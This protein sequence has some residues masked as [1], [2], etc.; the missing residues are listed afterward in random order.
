MDYET[1]ESGRG[2]TTFE[3]HILPQFAS[4]DFLHSRNKLCASILYQVPY[5]FYNI[6]T[7]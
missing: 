3:R 4:F 2:V 5:V 6:H 7:K 1:T